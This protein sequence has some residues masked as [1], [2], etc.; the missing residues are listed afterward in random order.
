ML[1]GWGCGVKGRGKTR[2]G[3]R[4]QDALPRVP[5]QDEADAI[6]GERGHTSDMQQQLGHGCV[7]SVLDALPLDTASPLRHCPRLRLCVYN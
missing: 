6:A 2:R 7:H 5:G 3:T 1:A 4:G